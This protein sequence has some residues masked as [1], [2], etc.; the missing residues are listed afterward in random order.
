MQYVW[1][2]FVLDFILG[3]PE[4]FHH[5][6]RFI[7][8]LIKA[9]EKSIRFACKS[10]NQLIIGGTVLVFI[11]ISVVFFLTFIIL[12]IAKAINPWLYIIV[13]VLLMYFAIAAKCLKNEGARIR[14][15]LINGDMENARKYLGYIVGRD[16]DKLEMPEIVRGTVETIAENTSDGVIAP[17]FYMIIGGAPLAMVYKAIN[18]MDSMIGYKN[19]NYLHFGKAAAILD[20]IANYI[21]ARITGYLMV[22]GAFA[23]RLDWKGSQKILK[24]D[25]KKHNSPNSGY[26]EAAAAGAL[27]VR[28][29]GVNSYFGVQ[30]QKPFIGD[31]TREF[32]VEDITRASR[33]MYA[34]SILFL[35]I[36]TIIFWKGFF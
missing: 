34:A 10:N 2:A 27:G 22:V 36:A 4:W 1:A 15:Y 35:Y 20:D 3:D 26:P 9:L 24:R 11:C 12:Q 25:S 16:V 14:K 33:L 32:E 29:G 31:R 8:R 17:L 23:L 30:S 5:P 28:L 19:E 7:G 21:P 6:I 18:T 13:N